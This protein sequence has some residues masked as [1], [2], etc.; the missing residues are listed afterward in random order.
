MS[1]SLYNKVVRIISQSIKFD[2]LEPYKNKGNSS[3]IGSGFFIDNKGTILTCS[4]LL[5]NS[6][7]VY[8]EVPFEGKRKYE[9]EIIMVCPKFDIAI[10]RM[11]T[12]KNKGYLNLIS[13]NDFYNIDSG[14]NVLAVGFP[15]GQNN[16]KLSQGIISGREDGLIQTTAPLNKGNSGGPLIMNNIVIGINA[17]KI[18]SASNIGYA[19]P[20]P[21]FHLIKTE[22]GNL[23]NRPIL[24]FHYFKSNK[25]YMDLNNVKCKGGVIINY[26][27]EESPAWNSGLRVGNVLCS[28]AGH[29]ID[30][31]GLIDRRW[32]NEK[33]GINDLINTFKNNSTIDI[34]FFNKNKVYNRKLKFNMYDYKISK[35]YPL[36]DDSDNKYEIF[37]GMIINELNMNNLQTLIKSKSGYKNTK[38]KNYARLVSW[39]KP[40]NRDKSRLIVTHIFPNSITKKS[41]VIKVTDII[42]SVNNIKVKTIGDYLNA[43]KKP[44]IN[45][46]KKYIKYTTI[47]NKILILLLGDI[48]KEEKSFSKVHK[49]PLSKTVKIYGIKNNNLSLKKVKRKI[50]TKKKKNKKPRKSKKK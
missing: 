46:K 19:V 11:K 49:Y 31:Y 43:L 14:T 3:S 26:V 44:L 13:T 4:H 50:I 25:E 12:Y 45:K 22:K 8:V 5:I 47:D 33:M 38:D 39:I 42:E 35:K 16:L 1:D 15:L 36:Y 24:G 10:I 9:A 48:L 21:H 40:E 30:N 27:N 34:S 23:I 37:A 20:I 2:W 17:S 32:F 29:K 7:K 41:E 28:L 18:G 6:R